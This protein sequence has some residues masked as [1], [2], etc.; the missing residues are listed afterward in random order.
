MAHHLWQLPAVASGTAADI[1]GVAAAVGIAGKATV[2][3][4]AVAAAVD[5]L[6]VAAVAVLRAA[7]WQNC[8]C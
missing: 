3:D 7:Q 5:Q 2:A 6:T 8:C 4:V 1:A